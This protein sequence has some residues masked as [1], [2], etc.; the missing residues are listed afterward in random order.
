MFCSK[1]GTQVPDGAAFC[2]KCGQPMGAVAA[3]PAAAP[4]APVPG[5]PPVKVPTHLVEAIIVTLLCCLPAGIAAIIYAGQ[6]NGKLAA[7]DVAGAMEA[8]R[9]AKM[10]TWIS[11]GA[12]LV[13]GII[14]AILIAS[15]NMK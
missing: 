6:V 14:Y 12:G 9:K 7:G 4:A 11:A 3:P 15:G 2:S 1:C 5:A 8:S 10:W 13:V